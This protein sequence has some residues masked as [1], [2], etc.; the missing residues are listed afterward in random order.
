MLEPK[1]RWCL[2]YGDMMEQVPFACLNP[3]YV[4]V[5]EA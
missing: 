4:P 1:D 3:W 2:F 5:S